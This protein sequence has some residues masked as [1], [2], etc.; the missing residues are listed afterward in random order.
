MDGLVKRVQTERAFASLVV[1]GVLEIGIAPEADKSLLEQWTA[2]RGLT[3]GTMQGPPIRTDEL[4]RV[5]AKIRKE[6]EQLPA[7]FPGI[8]VVFSN[9]LFPF[10]KDHRALIGELEE[11]VY[12]HDHLLGVVVGGGYMGTGMPDELM[13]QGQ[14]IYLRKTLFD[15]LIEEYAVLLNQFCSHKVSASSV[16]KFYNAFK[17]EASLL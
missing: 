1:D 8:V 15:L 5:R 11:A 4:Q 13:M 10:V 6:Q 12:H 14:H 7:G 16:T 2:A 3:V 17:P 9:N